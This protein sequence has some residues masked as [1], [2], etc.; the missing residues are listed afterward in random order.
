MHACHLPPF[1]AYTTPPA[2]HT[3]RC[4]RHDTLFGCHLCSHTQC[5]LPLSCI[6]T[7]AVGLQQ[8]RDSCHQVICEC[9][10]RV[11][12]CV[13]W[14][15]SSRANPCTTVSSHTWQD[16]EPTGK[17]SKRARRRRRRRKKKKG[18]DGAEPSQ[19]DAEPA[20]QPGDSRGG[21]AAAAASAAG[22]A[23]TAAAVD[24]DDAVLAEAM[25]ETARVHLEV[26]R[27]L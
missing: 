3:Q 15:C 26:R 12:C 13:A 19:D 16:P 17:A 8:Q 14:G 7:R 21:D 22:T 25:A 2:S 10:P 5:I 11:Q 6:S 9:A 20:A 24:D 27:A 18:G 4:A 1:L 23:A